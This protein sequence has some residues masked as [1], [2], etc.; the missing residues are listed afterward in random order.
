[1]TFIPPKDVNVRMD[2]ECSN[3]EIYL[4]NIQGPF[5]RSHASN[6]KDALNVAVA[7]NVR[8][9]KYIAN[10]ERNIHTCSYFQFNV[11]K[12]LAFINCM[13][14]RTKSSRRWQKPQASLHNHSSK[15]LTTVRLRF[16]QLHS[17]T[18]EII[19]LITPIK[20]Q[21]LKACIYF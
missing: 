4:W 10:V 19:K 8:I 11:Y 21:H 1:M 9:R 7:C 18:K 20:K 16:L 3:Y 6:Q 15:I 5:T 12:R 17:L 14:K 2:F 13:P